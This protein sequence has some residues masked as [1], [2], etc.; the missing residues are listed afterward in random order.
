MKVVIMRHG[1][2]VLGAGVIGQFLFEF[3]HFGAENVLT[4]GEHAGNAGVDLVF[5]TGLLGFEVN[6]FD[7]GFYAGNLL[8]LVP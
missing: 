3:R 4:V 5:D 2:A 6:K 7:H 8:T 1:D